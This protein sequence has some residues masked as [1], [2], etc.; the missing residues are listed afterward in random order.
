M[1]VPDVL[2]LR[3][4]ASGL[5]LVRIAIGVG[6]LAAPGPMLKLFGFPTEHDNASARIVGRFFGIRE[7]AIG[8]LTLAVVQDRPRSRDLF[9]LN[10]FVDGS[11][12]V[13]A[14]LA[15]VT[16]R[17]IPRAA[18]GTILVATPLAAGWL[19]LRRSAV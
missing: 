16:H 9:A 1:A 15:L 12:A 2:R 10:A 5:A 13:L 14:L 19:W 17:G 6:T 3:R 11:D 18:V 4:Y 8:A 7:V